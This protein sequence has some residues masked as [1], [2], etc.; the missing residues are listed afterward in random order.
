M[1]YEPGSHLQDF[2]LFSVFYYF[3]CFLLFRGEVITIGERL[4]DEEFK[5]V[6]KY[7]QMM[8]MLKTLKK[9]K[10]VNDAEYERIKE[11]LNKD[12][13]ISNYADLWDKEY[14]DKYLDSLR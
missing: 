8:Y 10:L 14:R 1:G 9:E 7:T 4:S 2:L 3:R 5:K 6:L 12:F 13:G 11:T